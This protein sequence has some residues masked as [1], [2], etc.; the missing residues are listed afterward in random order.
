MEVFECLEMTVLADLKFLSWYG[1]FWSERHGSSVMKVQT[2]VVELDEGCSSSS[3]YAVPVSAAF[4]DDSKAFEKICI[5][6]EMLEVSWQQLVGKWGKPWKDANILQG[7]LSDERTAKAVET[8]KKEWASSMKV[9]CNRLELSAEQQKKSRRTGTSKRV[10]GSYKGERGSFSTRLAKE[11]RTIMSLISSR[12]RGRKNVR[13]GCKNWLISDFLDRRLYQFKENCR[14]RRDCEGNF[15]IS[16]LHVIDSKSPMGACHRRRHEGFGICEIAY[17][18][19]DAHKV[20][21][22]KIKWIW[23]TWGCW[24]M[25][26]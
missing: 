14:R 10:L 26:G 12:L 18:H 4:W 23:T 19:I 17:Q 6:D 20:H 2:N 13:L 22:G 24:L 8:S 25:F 11:R 15:T 16:E 9:G 3:L 1:S 7:E 5:K 21:F